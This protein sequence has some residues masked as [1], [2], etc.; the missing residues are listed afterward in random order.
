MHRASPTSSPFQSAAWVGAHLRAY[1]T[2]DACVVTLRRD[3]ELT[4]AGVFRSRRVGPV[5]VLTSAPPQISDF[6]DVVLHPQDGVG[7]Q[8]AAGL[9]RT[10]GWD[11][12]DFPE[13]PPSADLW[14]LLR[15]WPGPAVRLPASECVIMDGTC[16]QEYTDGLPR[17]KRRQ[18]AQQQRGI[19][20]AGVTA[21][22]TDGG[23]DAVRRL[24]AFHRESW[25]GRAITPEHLTSR[26][27][28]LLVDAV[29]AMA[30]SSQAAVVEFH[31]HGRVRGA[32]LYLAGA[33]CVGI[34]LTGHAAELR[35][36]VNL[37]V[38]EMDAGFELVSE[39]GLS[40]FS[41][42]RGLEPYKLRLPARREVHERLV[43]VRP[44]SVAGRLVG[45]GMVSRPR[46]AMAARW[47]RERLAGWRTAR[48]SP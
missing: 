1:G 19:V 48:A 32:A 12:L 39:L 29:Q 16:L 3:G 15:S 23:A 30:K 21:V 8:L 18:L 20:R 34:Y 14:R 22:R 44:G 38:L 28:Q 41:L 25:A 9:V 45:H 43:L 27:E 46:A 10:P 40:Q 33:H 36:Q 11:V 2:D 6:T 35:E 26:F 5:T 47:G 4:A 31:Q 24:L 42:L 17:H 13:V 7:A 37:H